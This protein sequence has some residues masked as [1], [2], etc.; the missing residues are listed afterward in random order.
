MLVYS[1]LPGYTWMPSSAME[2][3]NIWRIRDITHQ[4]TVMCIRAAASFR[5][6]AG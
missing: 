3:S 5:G 6:I 1:L 2:F 4:R